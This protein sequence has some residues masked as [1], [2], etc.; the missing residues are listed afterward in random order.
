MA[1]LS[2][3]LSLIKTNPQ[4]WYNHTKRELDIFFDN[5]WHSIKNVDKDY[6]IKPE[7]MRCSEHCG[8]TVRGK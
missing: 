6:L 3:R 7:E 4:T 5:H 1:I 2:D 8:N